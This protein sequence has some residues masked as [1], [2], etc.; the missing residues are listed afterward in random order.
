[1]REMNG[2]DAMYA[3]VAGRLRIGAEPSRSSWSTLLAPRRVLRRAARA[4]VGAGLALYALGAPAIAQRVYVD[5]GYQFG[6]VDLATGVFEQIGPDHPEGLMGLTLGPGRSLLSLAFS[7]NLTAIDPVTG[8]TTLVGPTGLADCSTP[9]SPC[10]PSAANTLAGLSS[11]IYAT[12]FQNNLYAIDAST[13]AATLVGATGIPGIPFVPFAPGPNGVFGIYDQAL[14][15]VRGTLYAT[16]DA[17]IVDPVNGGLTVVV[18]PGLYRVDPLTAVTTFINA[19]PFGLGAVANIDDV[20]Y[21]FN[22]ATGQIVTLDVTNGST[23]VVGSFD[24][25]AGVLSSAYAAPTAVPEPDSIVFLGAGL[26]GI[27]AY[28]HHR[29]NRS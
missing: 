1:V 19:I 4:L 28:R 11:S 27:V 12:D 6:T 3:S 7:G 17:A 29:R 26:A 24:V 14:F 16:F 23:Q 25:A 9:V 8:L 18:S 20:I 15:A 5:N 22:N 10:G 2:H 13:G 21:A